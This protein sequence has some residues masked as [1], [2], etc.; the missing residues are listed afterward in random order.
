[1]VQIDLSQRRLDGKIGV[2]TGGSSGI[3]LATA[4]R[5]V[6][7]GAF[8]FIIGS[9]QSEINSAVKE[10]GINVTGIPGDVSNLND[11][12]RL[13]ETVRQ[14][15]GQIDVLFANA[16]LWEFAP[17]GTIT[18]ADFEKTFSVN[19]KGASVYSTKG[20]PIIS[21]RWF[22]HF[23]PFN[24]SIQ[25]SRRIECL[26]CYQGCYTIVCAFMDRRFETSQDPGQRHQ[27]WSHR[28]T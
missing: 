28:H 1:M 7:E 8:V 26:S 15:K 23:E 16:G 2:I 22:D 24:R 10:I 27:S 6:D 19:V 4:Q 11:L 18:E 20:A 5:F 17:L 14:Q 25:R 13:Y 21:E 3:G 9:R 12:D